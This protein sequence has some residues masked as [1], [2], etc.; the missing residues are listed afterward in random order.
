MPTVSAVRKGGILKHSARF[1][2]ELLVVFLF[3]AFAAE[4]WTHRRFASDPHSR[5]VT[6]GFAILV[7]GLGV[8]PFAYHVS[9]RLGKLLIATWLVFL[10]AFGI[11]GN[12]TR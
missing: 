9:P 8:L 7:L 3:L 10:V 4:T 11:A 2:A 5:F 1:A 12:F 6:S